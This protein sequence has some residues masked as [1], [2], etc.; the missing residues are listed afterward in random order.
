LFILNWLFFEIASISQEKVMHNQQSLFGITCLHQLV[1]RKQHG[2]WIHKSNVQLA[3]CVLDKI[4]VEEN[5]LL[6]K[7]LLF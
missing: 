1:L 2:I 5:V 3:H 7:Y 4:I 6:H